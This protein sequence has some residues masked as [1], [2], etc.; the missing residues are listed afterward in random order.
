MKLKDIAYLLA[1]R[2]RARTYGVEVRTFS[3]PRDGEVQYAQ[4]LHPRPTGWLAAA[5]R[6][7][8]PLRPCGADHR[9][10]SLR[11]PQLRHGVRHGRQ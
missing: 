8:P 4:W 9:L 2:P 5:S 10:A 6:E 11:V 3:L 7:V 1:L